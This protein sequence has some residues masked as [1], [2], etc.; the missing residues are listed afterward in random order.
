[1]NNFMTNVFLSQRAAFTKSCSARDK[2]LIFPDE[3]QEIKDISYT[4]HSPYANRMD[5]FRPK[6]MHERSLP[7]IINIH[8]GGLILG[9]KEFNRFYC[10]QLSK[11]GFLVFS[12]EYGLVPDVNVYDQFCDISN[13]MN[14]IEQL[15]VQYNGDSGHVYMVADSGGAY[16]AVYTAAM[17]KAPSIA[18]AAHVTP[19]GLKLNALGLISGMFYT[20]RFDKIGLFLPDFLYGKGYKKSA[21]A[22]YTNPENP[23]IV[24][25][26]PPC[27]LVTSHNDMLKQYTLDFEK[28][29][30]RHNIR[31][32]LTNYPSNKK[33]THAFSVFEPFWQLSI[34][35]INIM[36][37]FLNQF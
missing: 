23:E 16:L 9:S 32:I 5:L 20:T 35:E 18:K 11:A 26:L 25:A 30:T 27:Y 15:L 12:V 36:L 2:A 4:E 7:V 33:L 22:P 10:A 28:A 19:S 29:L 14:T 6:N 13:A 34:N 17:Q 8:G 31:H 1:M 21:F 24:K 3:I 37:D